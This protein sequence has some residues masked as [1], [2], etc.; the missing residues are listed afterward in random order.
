MGVPLSRSQ[1][2]CSRDDRFGSW[3]NSA[4]WRE[5]ISSTAEGVRGGCELVVK[6]QTVPGFDEHLAHEFVQGLVQSAIARGADPV[7]RLQHFRTLQQA[8]AVMAREPA[9]AQAAEQ[10]IQAID[11]ALL[12]LATVKL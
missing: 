11:R 9:A 3:L 8:T 10:L 12:E 1:K 5:R 4:E 6:V 7:A 2:P